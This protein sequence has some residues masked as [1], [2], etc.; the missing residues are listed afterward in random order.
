[1]A[2]TRRVEKSSGETIREMLDTLFSLFHLFFSSCPLDLQSLK[3]KLSTYLNP[4]GLSCHSEM[5]NAFHIQ[6][7]KN[8]SDQENML[9]WLE[10]IVYALKI[11]KCDWPKPTLQAAEYSFSS[12]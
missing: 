1:M 5:L 9:A 7:C 4:P 8:T 10:T 2:A 11:I 12:P 3:S 6:V